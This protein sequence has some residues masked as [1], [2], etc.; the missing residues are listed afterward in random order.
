MS[1]MKKVLVTGGTGFIGQPLVKALVGKGCAVRILSRNSQGKID[2]AVEV[3]SGDLTQPSTLQDLAQGCDTVFH[4]GGY[5]HAHS[6]PSFEEQEHHRL[7]NLEG[8][9]SLLQQAIASGVQ[10]F[11]FVSSVKAAGE[12]RHRCIDENNALEPRDPYGMIKLQ[13]EREVFARCKASS[14]EACV[15]RPALVYGCGVKG[16]LAQMIR[17]IGKGYFPPLCE[18]HNQ[19]SMVEVRDL[20]SALL[21]AAES[22]NA[23]GNTYIITDGEAYSTRRIYLALRHASGK[24]IPGWCMPGVWLR[25]LGLAGDGLEWLL[26]CS[27]PVNST[28]ASRLLDSACY[29]SVRAQA[30][31]GFSPR[32][33]LEDVCGEMV[34]EMQNA[35]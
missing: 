15:L 5:A 11:V 34:A 10:R 13:C 32:Y 22:P 9:R 25:M 7:I 6:R 23:R 16:N 28:L 20:V 30:D 2:E 18:E 12:D 1:V 3:I 24:K 29:A 31:L 14:M 21:L 8:T 4:L 19:R 17:A 33:R 35:E 26:R 27:M